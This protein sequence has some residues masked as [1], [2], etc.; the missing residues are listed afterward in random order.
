[1][2]VG[3]RQGSP[4]F[5]DQ[6]TPA[7]DP[8]AAEIDAVDVAF[9]DDEAFFACAKDAS[10]PD[11]ITDNNE[12]RMNAPRQDAQQFGIQDEYCRHDSQP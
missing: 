7:D 2:H 11:T 6:N 1:M 10:R 5:W 9:V 3:F 12:L 8:A 4:N